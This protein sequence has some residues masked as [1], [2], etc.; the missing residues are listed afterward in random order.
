VYSPRTTPKRG[1][2]DRR[3]GFR[4]SH[5]RVHG[6]PP[7]NSGRTNRRERSAS[8]GSKPTF[9]LESSFQRSKTSAK[10]GVTLIRK[11]TVENV[12]EATD[13]QT[14]ELDGELINDQEVVLDSGESRTLP[15]QRD[16]NRRPRS[17]RIRVRR[18]H[19]RRLR[20]GDIDG[21]SSRRVRRSTRRRMDRTRTAEPLRKMGTVEMGTAKRKPAKKVEP[22]ET[23]ELPLPTLLAHG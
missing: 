3:S 5:P 9:G 21:R 7:S 4:K 23:C 16:R 22:E 10:S 12:G 14:V 15:R 11:Q 2:R 13:T 1:H 19:R 6:R 20:N 8:E 17:R 18:F